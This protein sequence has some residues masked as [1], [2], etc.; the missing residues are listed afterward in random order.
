MILLILILINISSRIL[1]CIYIW[2]WNRVTLFYRKG[3]NMC[4]PTKFWIQTMMNS[5]WMYMLGTLIDGNSL[6]FNFFQVLWYSISF[7]WNDYNNLVSSI[8]IYNKE[9]GCQ[10][11]ALESTWKVLK[12]LAQFFT[13]NNDAH[14]AEL[15][16]FCFLFKFLITF[17]FRG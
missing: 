8:I 7:I 3:V 16:L 1:D 6:S 12:F 10:V 17:F 5:K 11:H 2:I 9:T 14:I 15:F 4:C 13:S